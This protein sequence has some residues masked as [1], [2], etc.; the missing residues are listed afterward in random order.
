MQRW[1]SSVIMTILIVRSCI[2]KIISA[3][4]AL[5][6]NNG[7]YI[8]GEDILMVGGLSLNEVYE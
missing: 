1:L 7:V 5:A 6:S 8:N 2:V 4:S 3:D